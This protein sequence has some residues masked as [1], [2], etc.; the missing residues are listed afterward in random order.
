MLR[1]WLS[2]SA[3]ASPNAASQP[4]HNPKPFEAL[5]AQPTTEQQAAPVESKHFQPVLGLLFFVGCLIIVWQVV[6]GYQAART[7]GWFLV[8]NA[9]VG[10]IGTTAYGLAC[11]ARGKKLLA[12]GH[13]PQSL[14]DFGMPF[15][16]FVVVIPFFLPKLLSALF[17]RSA[18]EEDFAMIRYQAQGM[19]M[20]GV[21]VTAALSIAYGK[22]L[23]TTPPVAGAQLNT[24]N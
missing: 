19:V 18:S 6:I 5:N 15:V 1:L 23:V 2:Y 16:T 10:I 7:S 13:K 20:V 9:A 11:A 14:L 12:V 8:L 4:L 24:E 3:N 21:F 22:R 17:Y